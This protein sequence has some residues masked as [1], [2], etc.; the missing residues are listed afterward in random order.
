MNHLLHHPPAPSPHMYSGF[1]QWLCMVVIHRGLCTGVMYI[2]IDFIYVDLFQ[3]DCI[4][5][6]R[7]KE[8]GGVKGG[9]LGPCEPL[10]PY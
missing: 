6:S 3:S 10:A 8:G 9:F 7:S 1:V 4:C 2:H 5:G